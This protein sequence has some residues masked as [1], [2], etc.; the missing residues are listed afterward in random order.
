MKVGDTINDK[1]ILWMDNPSPLIPDMLIKVGEFDGIVEDK[2]K[3]TSCGTSHTTTSK[4]YKNIKLI[5]LS[6]LK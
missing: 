1:T 3:C 4:K 2:S 5:R 6:E